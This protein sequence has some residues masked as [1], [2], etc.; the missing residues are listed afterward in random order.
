MAAAGPVAGSGE[1]GSA[2]VYFAKKLAN[3]EKTV[4]DKCVKRLRLWITCKVKAGKGLDEVDMLKLWKGL[5]YCMWFSDKP[6]IQEELADSLSEMIHLFKP[7]SSQGILFAKVFLTTMGREWH[8]IDRL[9]MDKFYM[10]VKKFIGSTYHYLGCSGW[11]Q[12]LVDETNDFL[13]QLFLSDQFPDGLKMF[14]S[15]HFL[16]Q[17]QESCTKQ[18]SFQRERVYFHCLSRSFKQLLI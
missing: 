13:V 18:H 14:W 7:H 3:T 4:R 5:F 16:Q 12:T 1:V 10:L 11:L 6:L 17:L 2:E 9:R 8:S 15:E